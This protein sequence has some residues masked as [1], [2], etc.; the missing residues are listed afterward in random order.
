MKR[1]I[2]LCLPIIMQAGCSLQETQKAVH[3]VAYPADVNG[4][5]VVLNPHDPNVRAYQAIK[6]D[7]LK[8][9]DTPVKPSDYLDKGIDIAAPAVGLYGGW[10]GLAG[11]IAWDVYRARKRKK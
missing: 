5:P 2:F 7:I 9:L 11:M 1:L 6:A 3:F 4:V 10:G 8:I